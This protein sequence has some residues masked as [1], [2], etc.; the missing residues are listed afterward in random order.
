MQ[1]EMSSDSFGYPTTNAPFQGNVSISL[2]EERCRYTA[3][4]L[5]RRPKGRALIHF[6]EK[7]VRNEVC[8]IKL[9]AFVQPDYLNLCNLANLASFIYYREFTFP[10]KDGK[11]GRR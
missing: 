2:Q 4:T 7:T 6:R 8:S 3:Y 9:C 11:M 10:V 1:L 5:V